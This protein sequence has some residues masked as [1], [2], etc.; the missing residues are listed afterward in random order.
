MGIVNKQSNL[1]MVYIGVDIGQSQDP[2][3]IVV[4]DPVIRDNEIHYVI[5]FLRRL[6]LGISYPAIIEEIIRIYQNIPEPE[7]KHRLHKQLWIDATG[8]GKPVVDLIRTNAPYIKLHEVF[9]AG[10][11]GRNK[12]NPW[13]RA[14]KLPKA[15]LVSRLQVMMSC[16]RIHLPKTEEAL[17][18]QEEL[19]NFTIKVNENANLK[20][21]A[22]KVG[23]HDDLV[24]ALGLASFAEFFP[25]L[26]TIKAFVV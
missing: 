3:A 10:G 26:P 23:A 2:T 17:V 4:A 1:Y 21:G 14:I 18:L 11:E 13:T 6:P 24:T 22:F 15:Y 20:F 16:G 19:M 7:G 25:S 9:I 5:R 12:I 8:V